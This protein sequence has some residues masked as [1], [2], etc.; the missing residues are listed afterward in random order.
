M[1][2]FPA[3]PQPRLR[4]RL[5]GLLD[6]A[7]WRCKRAAALS[8]LSGF[9]V[10]AD[11]QLVRHGDTD[12]FGRLAGPTQA[13]LEG[14]EVRFMAS[15]HAAHDEQDVAHRAAASTHCAFALM[16]ARVVGQR[17]QSR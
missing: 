17:S 7:S 9:G 2:P 3:F 11:E 15:H 1:E 5:T 13:L 16:L 8:Y 12:H 14:D 6:E 4:R 10:E